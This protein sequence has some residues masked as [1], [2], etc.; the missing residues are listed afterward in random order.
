[1][2]N[3][4]WQDTVELKPLEHSLEKFCIERNLPWEEIKR[5]SGT[6]AFIKKNA[7]T[8]LQIHLAEDTN[9][10]HGGVLVGKPYY[11]SQDGRY[12][13]VIERA[14]PALDTEG[15]PVHLQFTPEAWTFISGIMVQEFPD[16]IILGWYHSHP[17]L[18]VFMSGTDRA[19]QKAFY[20]HEWNLA[21]VVDPMTVKAGWFNGPDCLPMDNHHVFAYQDI[22]FVKPLIP[23]PD[24]TGQPEEEEYRHSFRLESLRW[25]L[26]V[27]ALLAAFMVGVWYMGKNRV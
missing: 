8:D 2:S 18:G 21:V 20:N 10:E 13:S 26:P 24:V 23:T 17:G 5:S 9:R 27:G 12:F 11:D 7:L 1:M 19:T 16:F 14:L 6:V 3:I 25:L 4:E 22:G 15:S